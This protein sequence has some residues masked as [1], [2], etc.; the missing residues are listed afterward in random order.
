MKKYKVGDLVRLKDVVTV[1]KRLVGKM[2]LISA[3]VNSKDVS[4]HQS[5]DKALPLYT[6]Y[7]NEGCKNLFWEEAEF[8][9]ASDGE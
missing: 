4:Y 7:V 1:P 8:E 9:L 2:G 3:I 5:Y 6:L